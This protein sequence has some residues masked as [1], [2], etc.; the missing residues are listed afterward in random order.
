MQKKLLGFL[1]SIFSLMFYSQIAI[2]EGFEGATTPSGWTYSGFDRVT[3]T[4][5]TPCAGN[6]AI[7]S[8]L[9]SALPTSSA[10]YSATNSNGSSISVS[11]KYR[12]IAV[13][14]SNPAV[15]GNF[16]VEYSQS[17]TS[18]NFQL[19]G[20]QIN[21]TAPSASCGTFT[22]NVSANNVTGDN[23]FKITANNIGTGDWKLII[24]DVII[25]Q[26]IPCY[27]AMNLDPTNVTANSAQVNWFANGIVPANGIDIYYS[28]AN[29]APTSTTIPTINGAVGSSK[30]ISSLLAGTKYYV[31]VRSNCATEISEWSLPKTFTT[32]CSQTLPYNQD[33]ETTALSSIPNCSTQQN[34]NWTTIAIASGLG[35][36]QGKVLSCNFNNISVVDY[37]WFTYK[38][39]LQ[40]GIT[41]VVKFK[42]GN[43]SI[44]YAGT[45]RLKVAYGNAA[46]AASMTNVIKDFTNSQTTNAETEIIYFTPTADGEYYFG[47]NAYTPTGVT[48]KGFFLLD[49][50]SID[51]SN[52]CLIPNNISVSSVTQNSAIVSWNA[53]TSVP[54]QGY[55][56]YYSTNDTEPT[57]STVPSYQGI[58]G[59]TQ[60]LSSLTAGKRYY[61]WVR[62][63][64]SS[65]QLS[66]WNGTS[67]YAACPPA[68]NVSYLE[69]F[70]GSIAGSLPNCT[71]STGNS[72]TVYNNYS[73][74]STGGNIVKWPTKALHFNEVDN[75]SEWF[76]TSGINME[77]GKQYKITYQYGRG[78]SF[79][80]DKLKVAYGT[81]PVPSSMINMLAN[82]AGV[83]VGVLDD[84][85]TF[86]VPS[87]GVYY[88]GFNAYVASG[89]TRALAIDNIIIIE[90]GVLAVEDVNK[91]SDTSIYPNPFNDKLNISNIK[92]VKSITINDISGKLVKTFPAEKELNVQNL[93]IGVYIVSLKYKDG[94]IKTFKIVKK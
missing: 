84:A 58:S 2:N 16:K 72:W 19:V 80:N 4:T 6:A 37:W 25:N 48:G 69:D 28:T 45:Q 85:H 18:N 12:I 41:Y 57:A 9:S 5:E 79:A 78:S 67:F 8:H 73:Y 35:F 39:N 50:I 38:F 62:S 20:S 51:I 86:T 75:S 47:F 1:L 53:S 34:G 52:N 46:N 65:S 89:F 22:G 7:L 15:S 71:S 42:K 70:E 55:D 10:L 54:A 88:F 74:P 31:W 64:C 40:A 91:K 26:T 13:D 82:Y 24:D 68:F 11:F 21:V 44:R 49:D 63:R 93:N 30:I 90:D 23:R 32:L 76:F 60:N 27:T 29:T 66:D 83:P 56:I 17:G 3:S 33:F 43:E 59:L 94:S 87:N 61:V 77:V 81:S 14:P 92:N 36:S